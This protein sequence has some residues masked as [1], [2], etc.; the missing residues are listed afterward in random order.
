MDFPSR[1][2]CVACLLLFSCSSRDDLD[3][4]R[5]TPEGAQKTSAPQ[6]SKTGETPKETVATDLFAGRPLFLGYR[7]GALVISAGSASFA[8][9]IDGGT[10]RDWHRGLELADDKGESRSA[11][12]VKGLAAEVYFPLDSDPG[13]I[14]KTGDALQIRFTA[15]PAVENQL[16]SVF[17]NERKLG[18]LRMPKKEWQSYSMK[19][20]AEAVVEGENKLRFY[21]RSTGKFGDIASAAAFQ[22]FVV[23]GSLSD[24][25]AFATKSH[26]LG[27]ERKPSIVVDGATRL[28]TYLLVPKGKSTLSFS[29]AG[30]GKAS[31]R[32]RSVGQSK[33]EERWT[34]APSA[35]AWEQA[36]LALDSYAGRIVRLDFLSSDAMAWSGMAVW[37]LKLEEPSVKRKVPNHIILW[38]VSSLRSDR[39]REEVGRAFQRFGDGNFRVPEA[40]TSVPT[41]GG[42][43]ATAMTGRMRVRS[44]IPDSYTTL[45]EHLQKSGYATALI[46][47]N[48]FVNDGA[49][50]AQGF[51]HYDNPMRRQHH[52]GARTLWRQASRFLQKHKTQRSFVHVVTVEP[53]VPYRPSDEAL[54][55]EWVLPAP[56]APA[57][58][59]SL[60]EQIAKGKRVMSANERAYIRALYDATVADSGSAFA[61]MLDEVSELGLTGE[62]AIVLSGDHG[63]EMWERDTFGHGASLHQESLRTPLIISAPGVGALQP[64]RRASSIDLMPTLLDLAGL[65]PG[66]EVEGRSLLRSPAELEL[67]PTLAAASDGSRSLQWAQYKLVHLPA[68]RLQLFDLKSDPAEQ[69]DISQTHPMAARALRNLL[70]TGLAYESVWSTARWGSLSSPREAFARDQGF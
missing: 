45:A 67:R 6:E 60:G 58:T 48:G 50:F 1:F 39:L 14:Q 38:S 56:F 24:E 40:Q 68:G 29:F 61:A 70:A 12:L 13:G 59:L 2:A 51:D 37:K 62:V 9:F 53:H 11:S 25:E 5:R 16:V 30:Q 42:S 4:Q 21:F 49:G 66:P 35:E 63:E 52:F 44:S 46:S 65:E 18:D 64:P 10:R 43:H 32:I 54:A 26:K 3:G 33:S 28:S 34:Q 36:T 17:L 47:G 20:P 22:Q 57:K 19:A 23:G 41:A 15:L 27:G 55:R 7:S 69:R 31:L 8:K